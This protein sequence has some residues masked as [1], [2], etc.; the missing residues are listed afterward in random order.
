MFFLNEDK[1]EINIML[2]EFYIYCLFIRRLLVLKMVTS[3]SE[4]SNETDN[5]IKK[6][7]YECSCFFIYL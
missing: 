5:E 6:F 7:Y 4:M 2:N 3:I 1:L